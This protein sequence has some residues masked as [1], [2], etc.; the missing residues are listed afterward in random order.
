M[1]C[2]G[3]R[4]SNQ[5]VFVVNTDSEFRSYP[6]IEKSLAEL[7][8]DTKNPLKHASGTVFTQNEANNDGVLGPLLKG[9]RPENV[10]VV[11]PGNYWVI[12]AKRDHNQM[13]A[14]IA[15]AKEYAKLINKSET[16]ECSF[17]TGVAGTE[18]HTFLVETYFLH[19][20]E[21]K[22]V[23]INN[24]EATG[25]LSPSQ[26]STILSSNS[27][28]LSQ[29]LVD[30][31][32]FL[33]TANEINEILHKG[34]VNKK[35]RARVIS[36]L[37]L[38]LVSDEYMRISDDP[39]TLIEDINARVKSLLRSYGKENFAAEIAIHLPTSRDNHAK[40]RRALVDSIQL[41]K[42]INIK[43]ALNSG[44]DLLG[45]FY[46]IFLKYANDS[47]EIGI[48]LT[49]RHITRFAAEVLDIT[50]KDYVYDPACG[51]GGF[52]VASFD[53]IKR[54][55]PYSVDVFKKSQIHGV[56]Q[57]PEVVGLAIVNM[58]FRGDGSS[59]IIEGNSFDN[60]FFEINNTRRHLKTDELDKA[61]EEGA[62]IRPY[63]SKVLM[64]PPF[65]QDEKEYQFVDHALNQMIEGGLLFAVIPTSVMASN[66][67]REIAWR[68]QLLK[69]HTLKAVIKLSEDLFLPNA[70]KGTYAVI[71]EAWKPHDDKEVFWAL[72]DDGYVMKKAKRLPSSNVPSN[73]DLIESELKT[74]LSG[75]TVTNKYTNVIHISKINNSDR[76]VDCSPEAHMPYRF[77]DN[78][79]ISR[80]S[81]SLANSLIKQNDIQDFNLCGITYELFYI[82]DVFDSIQRGDCP[83]VSLLG[84]GQ[85]PT[86][87]TTE[88]NNGIDGFYSSDVSTIFED[89]ITIPANGSK[90]RAFYHPYKFYA[91]PDV[92]ICKVKSPFENLETKLYLCSI[93]NQSSWRFSYFRK[94]N[95]YKL[96]KDVRIPLPVKNGEIDYQ[97]I[98][99]QVHKTM[100]YKVIKNIIKN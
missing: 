3:S 38:A 31:Q 46:E 84:D 61:R 63:I 8:W 44:T 11:V 50:D 15:E 17:I 65:A 72:M 64:N 39:T 67:A 6:F 62:L 43:S 83:S 14:A 76:I 4:K 34:A 86:I 5:G 25:F 99:D 53:K 55:Y 68:K 78:I 79:D 90:Y 95:E 41:L 19:E 51:T 48:V 96:N 1:Q 22:V 27:P 33:D 87:T 37:L 85:I 75:G 30:E 66:T 47:K 7:G 42:N 58:I 89:C 97:Y 23:S 32:V 69:R 92:L 81:L 9:S 36:S 13:S 40:N 52:L 88:E 98:Q 91:V 26:T 24:R 49:P 29:Q 100:G 57:D 12:E 71:I 94:C 93:L 35:N 56:D 20:G 28:D 77:D 73:I 70:H 18:D 80:V 59:N 21:W 16:V 60:H 2:C 45:Q 10:V 82:A 74:F 54:D